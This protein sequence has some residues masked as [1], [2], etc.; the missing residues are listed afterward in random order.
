MH[1]CTSIPLGLFVGS[2]LIRADLCRVMGWLAACERGGLQRVNGVACSVRTG[3]L[4]AC[5]RECLRGLAEATSGPSWPRGGGFSYIHHF[6][7]FVF[8]Y[9]SNSTIEPAYHESQDCCYKQEWM[10][11][12]FVIRSVNSSR[13]FYV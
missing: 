5:E 1:R 2:W 7:C 6:L 12:A 8:L 9:P 3:W 10:R 11:E 13:T 4:A